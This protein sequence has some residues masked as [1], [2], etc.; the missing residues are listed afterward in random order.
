M[1]QELLHKYFKGDTSVEEEKLILNWVDEAEENRKTLQKERM[2]FDIALFTDAKKQK[3][4]RAV[5]GTRILTMLRWGARIAA[6]IV[7]VLSLGYL[8]KDYQYDKVAQVQTV[9]VPAGQ[10]AEITLADGTKVWLNAQSKLTYASNFGRT[11]RNVELDG[12]AYFEVAK[13]KEIPFNVN[14]EMNQVRVVGTHFNVCAY[15]GTHEF[16]TTLME[17]IV[18]IYLRG[19]EE[20]VARLTENEVFTLVGTKYKKTSL[21]NT[22][23]LRWKEGLYCFDDAPF[24]TILAKLEKYYKVKIIVQNPKV[25]DYRCT[26]KFKDQD[27]I[28]HVL[29]VI[30]KDHKFKYKVNEERDSIYIN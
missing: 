30:Q 1:N 18:D 9:S 22:D 3:R 21:A 28:E 27:G 15:K 26:G 8:W 16:E 12:E 25:L 2:L 10:R 13:N 6:I 5:T 20:P 4:E 17:G 23:Y 29:K 7:V 24:N 11:D 19:G 14:T